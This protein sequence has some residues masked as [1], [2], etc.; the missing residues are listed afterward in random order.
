MGTPRKKT[1]GMTEGKWRMRR[2][3]RREE[4]RLGMNGR[5]GVLP[6][7]TVCCDV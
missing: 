1:L 3:V 4:R 2:K 7:H 5:T 6:V